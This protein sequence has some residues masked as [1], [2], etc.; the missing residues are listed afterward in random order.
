MVCSAGFGP[1]VRKLK[2]LGVFGGWIVETPFFQR[3]S[4]TLLFFECS[5]GIQ[6]CNGTAPAVRAQ[7]IGTSGWARPTLDQT[8]GRSDSCQF[9]LRIYLLALSDGLT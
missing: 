1:L 7:A 8:K 3:Y 5:H 4:Q 2:H 9:S 6:E